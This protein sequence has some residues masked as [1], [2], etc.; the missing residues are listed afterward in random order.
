[1]MYAMD[2]QQAM[3]FLESTKKFGSQLGLESIKNLM[4]LLGN[5]Q[6]KIPVIHIAGTNGKGSVGAM[7]SSVL[8]HAGYRTG[9]FSTPDVF[10]YEEEFRLNGKP[11]E[12]VRL[13]EIFTQ[14]AE[15]CQLLV[16][17]G[18]PHPTRFEVETAAA[19]LWFYEEKCDISIIEVGMGGETDA[20]NIIQKPMLSILTSISMDHMGFL[21]NQLTDIAKVKSGIIKKNCPVVFMEQQQEAMDVI[22]TRCKEMNSAYICSKLCEVQDF[23]VDQG[24]IVFSWKDGWKRIRLGLSGEFQLEN[25]VCVLNALNILKNAYPKIGECAV[26]LGLEETKWPGR[27]EKIGASPDFYIDGA[28]NEDAVRKLRRTIDLCLPDKKIF[29]I[30]GVL[31]DKDYEQMIRSMF[32]KGDRVWTVTPDNPRAL[33]GKSLAQQLQRY[34]IN[35][36]S[37]EN[38]KDAVSY[39]LR[40]A[41]R[42]DVILAFGSLSY[43]KEIREAYDNK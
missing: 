5:V 2:Y 12:K 13:A 21:G 23:Y 20:T 25:A 26:R 19:F 17:E 41:Q 24:R 29:Y 3:G 6:D 1:M 31:A 22:L 43:L 32:R 11:I 30:M 16:A 37:C 35:A 10:S 7:L 15:K 9:H 28:H 14:V 27:F 42:E 18:K 38:V 34:K 4:T 40:E 8:Q 39:A 33:D 36:D